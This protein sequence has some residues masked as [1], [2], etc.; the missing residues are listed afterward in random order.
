MIGGVN[1]QGNKLVASL[2]SWG[3]YHVNP[4]SMRSALGAGLEYSKVF[5]K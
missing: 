4:T 5:L 2:L 3:L 1:I